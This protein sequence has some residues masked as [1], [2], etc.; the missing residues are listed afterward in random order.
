MNAAV[1]HGNRTIVIEDIP[2]PEIGDNEILVKVMMCGV[3]G[4]DIHIFNGDQGAAECTPPVVLGHEFSGIVAKVGKSVTNVRIGDRVVIDPN[5]S[6]GQCDFCK[7]GVNHYCRNLVGIGTTVN[8]GFEEYCAVCATQAYKMP[9]NLTF[10][11]AAFAEPISCCLHGIDLSNIKPG[12]TVMILGA[13]PIGLIMLQLVKISGAAE[14]IVQEPIESKRE[15]AKALGAKLTID[16]TVNDVR[17]VLKDNNIGNI[18]TVIE[19]VGTKKTIEDAIELAGKCGTVMLFGLTKPDCE[20]NVRP[21][22]TFK[23]EL[24]ITSSFINPH[25]MHRALSLL[26]SG[27]IE[28]HPLIANILPLAD[29]TRA[30]TDKSICKNGKV[31]IRIQ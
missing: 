19:C 3:C 21:F 23:N 12:S 13:G 4:T 15:L 29:I 26:K 31:L 9:N 30:F 25:T 14:I 20:I 5:N 17:T 24:T 10:E 2:M 16:P 28:L 6:C 8:G 22:Q 1:Y 11:E 27:K 18:D 7:A